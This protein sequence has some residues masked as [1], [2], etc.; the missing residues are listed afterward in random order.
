MCVEGVEGEVAVEDRRKARKICNVGNLE[1]VKGI[2]KNRKWEDN[3]DQTNIEDQNDP[4]V[5]AFSD[6][7]RD[8]GINIL[9][10]ARKSMIEN[11]R[12]T[13]WFYYELEE[14]REKIAQ[15]ERIKDEPSFGY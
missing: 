14:I 4:N 12:S 13:K 3:Q 1:I 15:M 9:D 6:N 10:S 5:W 8:T 2:F 7:S 11:L